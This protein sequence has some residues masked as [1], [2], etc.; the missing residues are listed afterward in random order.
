MPT[1]TAISSG[2]Q[3]DHPLPGPPLKQVDQ[4]ADEQ[5]AGESVVGNARQTWIAGEVEQA[6]HHPPDRSA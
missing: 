6:C 1:A 5:N 2:L 4:R 3:P